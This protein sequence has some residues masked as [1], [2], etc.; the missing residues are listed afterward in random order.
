MHPPLLYYSCYTWLAFQ[1]NQLYYHGSHYV[2]CTPFFHPESKFC[3]V[4]N[5]PST[6][7]PRE[8]YFNLRDEVE[9]GDRHSAKIQQNKLGIQRGAQIRRDAGQISDDQYAEIVS[10]VSIAETRDFRPLIYVIAATSVTPKQVP[11][12]DRAHPLSEEFI[13]S[14]L[15]RE[16][17]DVLELS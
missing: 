17:F 8:I 7:S 13:I 16:M 9:R 1:I 10:A 3:R 4:N 15:K 2:W 11:I 5:V 12:K 14:D 6:S